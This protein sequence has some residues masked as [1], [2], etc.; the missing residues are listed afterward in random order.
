MSLIGPTNYIATVTHKNGY[1]QG[2]STLTAFNHYL[3]QQEALAM[4]IRSIDDLMQRYSGTSTD[5]QTQSLSAS[6][7]KKRRK[8]FGF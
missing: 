8:I 6:I 3:A 1:T 4:S 7:E 2:F 5:T